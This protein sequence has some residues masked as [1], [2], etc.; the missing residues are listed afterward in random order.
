M[1]VNAHKLT[2]AECRTYPATE[3]G[4]RPFAVIGFDDD[5]GSRVNLF[6]DN[7]DE[8]RE[9]AEA[10]RLLADSLEERQS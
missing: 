10:L 4:E 9:H 8:M 7:A 5:Q 6:F 1:D 2:R 3:H